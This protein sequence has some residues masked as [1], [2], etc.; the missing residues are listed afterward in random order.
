M[1]LSQVLG[2]VPVGQ[3]VEIPQDGN[4]KTVATRTGPDEALMKLIDLTSGRVVMEFETNLSAP[5][6][7]NMKFDSHFWTVII[8]GT[9]LPPGSLLPP[10]YHNLGVNAAARTI[11][12][13]TRVI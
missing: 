5:T 1:Y 3:S 8:N 12:A 6:S 10:S 4:I 9:K 2:P 7:R 11:T 13:S